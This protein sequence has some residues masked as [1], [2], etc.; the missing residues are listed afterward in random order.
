MDRENKRSCEVMSHPGLKESEM[1]HMLNM[2]TKIEYYNELAQI[3][4]LLLN[5]ENIDS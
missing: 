5:T 4:V 1:S 2:F 3:D